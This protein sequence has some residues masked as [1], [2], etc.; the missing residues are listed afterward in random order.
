[1]ADG[2]SADVPTIAVLKAVEHSLCTY[3]VRTA[4]LAH[5]SHPAPQWGFSRYASSPRPAPAPAH[6]IERV[7]CHG[8]CFLRPHTTGHPG[9]AATPPCF[10]AASRPAAP[11]PP[12]MEARMR[13]MLHQCRS[14]RRRTAA[15]GGRY[16]EHA[17]VLQ[18]PTSAGDCL[19]P[20]QPSGHAP[21]IPRARAT[22]QP[23]TAIEGMGETLL[24]AD[25]TAQAQRNPKSGR[26]AAALR[27]WPCAPLRPRVPFG[28]N[29]SEVDCLS[30]ACT[31]GARSKPPLRGFLVSLAH[32]CELSSGS[33]C[34]VL[35]AAS[36]MPRI[37]LSGLAMSELGISSR[38]PRPRAVPG[39][40]QPGRRTRLATTKT[41]EARL[42]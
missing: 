1:M 11:S 20:W 18:S 23:V 7:A 13:Y 16:H 26:T 31:A 15:A 33:L 10:A 25:G 4:A 34:A 2:Q 17:C 19:A 35:S 24:H 9:Q 28:R 14:K 30:R 27:A 41:M 32:G 6:P 3:V 12:R 37:L 29:E 36:I 22:N 40:G 38:M 5:A 21:P 42:A 39:A 8:A